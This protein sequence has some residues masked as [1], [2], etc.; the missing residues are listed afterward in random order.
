MEVHIKNADGVWLTSAKADLG[1]AAVQLFAA[2]GW[3]ANPVSDFSGVSLL[4]QPGP[5]TWPITSMPF[6]MVRVD[7]CVC[8]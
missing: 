7:R 3:P 4:N 8:D 6:M 5:Q 1:A 2:G